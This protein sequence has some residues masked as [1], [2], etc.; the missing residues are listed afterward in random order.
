MRALLNTHVLEFTG[1]EDF[2]AFHALDEFS[3]FVTADDLDARVF[4]GLLTV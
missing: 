4:A 1:L 2:A 3:L